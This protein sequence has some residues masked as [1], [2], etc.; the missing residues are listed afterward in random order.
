MREY[1]LWYFFCHL[2]KLKK[3][4]WWHLKS[5]SW[6]FQ[7]ATPPTVLGH[8]E[9]NFV[10]N[11]AVIGEYK[12]INFWCFSI[13]QK[14]QILKFLTWK[15]I[16]KIL[17]CAISWKWLTVEQNGWKFGTC[18]PMYV[19]WYGGYFSCL[20]LW[21]QFEVIRCTLQNS[22][23]DIF[24]RLLHPQFSFNF[25]FEKALTRGNYLQLLFLVIRRI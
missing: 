6:K 3:L 7:G 22:D 8:S 4:H 14:L 25:T 1:R 11:K 18:G 2:P 10:I 9:S 21:V 12:I 20:I 16:G 19:L 15:S 5:W 23:V 17:K 13:R 24:K